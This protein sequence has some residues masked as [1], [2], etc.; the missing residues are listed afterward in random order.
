LLDPNCAVAFSEAAGPAR[1]LWQIDA[2][3]T[4]P[5]GAPTSIDTTFTVPMDGVVV[6]WTWDSG[7]G[8]YLRSQDGQPHLTVSGAQISALNVVEISTVYIPSPADARSP[9]PIT[10]GSGPAVVHRNGRALTGIWTR[11]TPYD[12]FEFF[13]TLTG[14]SIPLDTGTTFIEL[15]RT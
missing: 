1:P 5:L 2:W 9:T 14:Q 8:T 12:P 15:G 6:D 11:L 7:T 4:P 13:E 3:W 10:V